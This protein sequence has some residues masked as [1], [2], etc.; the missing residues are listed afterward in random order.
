[1]LRL[2]EDR[3][4]ARTDARRGGLEARVRGTLVHRLMEELD[5]SRPVLPSG[6]EID[7][8]AGE[9]GEKVGEAERAEMAALVEGCLKTATGARLVAA[10][11][12]RREHPFAFSLGAGEPLITG[13]ID[14]LAVEPDGT[15]LVLDYKSDHVG[16]GADLPALVEREYS[17]QRLLYA[18]AVLREGAAE[19]EIVHWFLER[20]HDPV[21]ARF[22]AAGREQLEAALRA[23]SEWAAT[24]PY[25][26][27][28]RPH[29]GLCLTCPGRTG[30]CSWTDA[31]T[32]REDPEQL[33]AGAHA[34][35]KAP[36]GGD[37]PDEGAQLGL[38]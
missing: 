5:F 24:R 16:P 22:D 1:V 7:R 11:A 18:L 20:P 27:S 23:K 19:V 10:S 6:A 15:V 34:P 37:A 14:L 9:L 32:L 35:A 2:G 38:F 26:V 4:A 3:S 12:V 13:F 29:R 33:P 31:E 36:S 21:R 25:E 8:L 28:S 30:L 17:I